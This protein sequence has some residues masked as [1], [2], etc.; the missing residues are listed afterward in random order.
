M[1]KKKLR[2]YLWDAKDPDS[3]NLN[4][5]SLFEAKNFLFYKF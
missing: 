2:S 1:K 4:K 5:G 3:I